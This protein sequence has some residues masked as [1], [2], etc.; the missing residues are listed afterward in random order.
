MSEEFC[1]VIVG[2]GNISNTYVNAIEKI[3]N[4]RIAGFVSRS[5]KL[6]SVVES[7][8]SGFEIAE[9][10]S[11]IKAHFD[12][13]IICTPN[14]LHHQGAIEAA[15]LGK[16]VLTEKPLDISIENMN[17]MIEKCKNANVKLGVAY[18]RRMSPDNIVMKKILEENKLGR[19]YAADLS[20]K[21]Y[22][23]DNYYNSGKYRGT[24]SIDGGGPFMQQASHNIDLY[25]WFFGKPEKIVSL[26]GTVAH[27][28]ETED[29]GTAILKYENGMIG[30]ITA[31]TSAKPGFD[32]RLEIYGE[33][34]S[35]VM[36]NDLI[37]FW[38]VEGMEN[39]S[40]SA[41]I[42]IHSGAAS[43]SV[44]DTSGHEAI[45]KNFINAVRENKEPAV[46]GESARAA[47]EIILQ[48]YESNI[49]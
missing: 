30:T 15:S 32:P 33:N 1:F 23:D 22:R 17:Q 34:G 31:S 19:I 11:G 49:A 4:T 44:K 35:V 36:E 16:H 48:I 38:S 41:G 37:T 25:G 9:N 24:W 7:K 40:K 18:Q 47:T 10:L 8:S 2:T 45:I 14:G 28:I 3:E 20:V 42:K 46:P 27:K 21:N 39:P 29:H 12:A 13:V 26:F 43:A 5:L 6:P